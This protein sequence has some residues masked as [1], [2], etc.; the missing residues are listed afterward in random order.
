MVVT[1]EYQLAISAL[2]HHTVQ[3]MSVKKSELWQRLRAARQAAGITQQVVADACGVSRTA[4]AL[5]TSQD[6]ETRTN[7]SL[8]HMR[9]FA[10]ITG[11]PLDWLLS[12][13]SSPN[14]AFKFI[15][16]AA[17]AGEQPTNGSAPK[18]RRAN[19]S[20]P[21]V[22]PDIRQNGRI[23]VFAK[24]PEQVAEKLRQLATEPGQKHLIV[25]DDSIKII[26]AADPSAA[27]SAVIALLK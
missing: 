2:L 23:F 22:L 17:E 21:D 13:M 12:D 15:A 1:P 18:V 16:E 8:A 3:S 10:E 26:T 25:L 19:A 27:L 7:P 5:W 4:V 9:S 20:T 6:P 11:V 24:T 14:E